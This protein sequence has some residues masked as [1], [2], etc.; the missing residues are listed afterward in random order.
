MTKSPLVTRDV[1]I[2]KDIDEDAIIPPEFRKK[3]GR[4][5]ILS[6]SFSTVDAAL[7]RIFEPGAPSPKERLAAMK[8][9]S[10]SGLLSGAC[11]MP[12]LPYLSDSEEALR[13]TLKAIKEHGGRFALISTL[14]LYGEGGGSCKD[15]YLKVIEEHFPHLRERYKELYGEG[16]GPHA[17]YC[18]ELFE[19]A[20]RLCAEYGLSTRIFPAD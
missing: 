20:E 11:I 8:K 1:D 6:F 15:T 2:L 12:V 13:E 5:V 17:A 3:G 18:R 10:D 19:R 9:A 14:T 4:G 16:T 7:A